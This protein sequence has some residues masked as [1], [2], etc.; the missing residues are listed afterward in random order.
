[1]KVDT[2][3]LQVIS[4]ALWENEPRYV[5]GA[6]RNIELAKTIYPDWVCRIFVSSQLI[7][8]DI[9]VRFKE[10]D[11]VD[12]VLVDEEPMD[13]SLWRFW[14]ADDP[15]VEL[16]VVRDTDCRLSIREKEA[17]DEWIESGKEFHVMRDHPFQMSPIVP[18]L[19]GMRVGNFKDM[20]VKTT[21]FVEGNYYKRR[22]GLAEAFIWG[23]IWPLAQSNSFI[24]DPYFS[25]DCHFPVPERD[26]D[27]LCWFVGEKFDQEDNH[28]PHRRSLLKMDRKVY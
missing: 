16:F 5:E 28:T 7:P 6:F 9:I 14:V 27:E 21:R 15:S 25:E 10:H 19:W 17:V 23:T 8:E 2:P 1:M 12:V 11:N 22:G 24:H 26:V 18:N 3:S 4:F 20:R 13:G